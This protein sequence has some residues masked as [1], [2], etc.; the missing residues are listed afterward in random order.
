MIPLHSSSTLVLSLNLARYAREGTHTCMCTRIKLLTKKTV[1]YCQTD[2]HKQPPAPPGRRS[3][4]GFSCLCGKRSGF[5]R[6]NVRTGVLAPPSDGQVGRPEQ[7][8]YVSDSR[9][10]ANALV[11]LFG[12]TVLLSLGEKSRLM[13]QRKELALQSLEGGRMVGGGGRGV[14]SSELRF[15]L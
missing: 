8:S 14:G 7:F 13:E 10:T 2:S 11:R 3:E 5:S 4:C 9:A 6:L 15:L 12:P 1:P